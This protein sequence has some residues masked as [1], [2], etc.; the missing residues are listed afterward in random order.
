VQERSGTVVAATQ[1]P[2]K[3]QGGRA[4]MHTLASGETLWSV[5]QRYGVTV[6]DIQRWNNIR[7]P[8]EL[9]AGKQLTVAAP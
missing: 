8:R 6:E 2:A 1:A 9:P 5:A 3:A 7:D 4:T